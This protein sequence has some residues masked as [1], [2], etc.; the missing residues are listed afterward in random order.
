S[1]HYSNKQEEDLEKLRLQVELAF[2]HKKTWDMVRKI[3]GKSKSNHVH[4]LNSDGKLITSVPDIANTLADAFSHNSSAEH[5]S[6][7]FLRVKNAKEKRPLKFKSKNTEDYNKVF[8]IRELKDSLN[9]ANDTAA[10]PD[11][12]P[13]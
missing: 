5:C 9:R 1:A 10:G 11:E 6:K 3:Q 7:E 12:I 4:H 13:Y 2:F 8:S